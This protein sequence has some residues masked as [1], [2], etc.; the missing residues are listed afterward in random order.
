MPRILFVDD[1]PLARE[2]AAAR[3][4]GDGWRVDTAADG[5]EACRLLNADGYDAVVLDLEMPK[6]D[7]FDALKY[8]R[9]HAAHARTPVAVL[10]SHADDDTRERALDAGADLFLTKPADWPAVRDALAALIGR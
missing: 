2:A 5:A 10:T 6:F 4:D 9:S 7:G 8:L 3:L 1:D